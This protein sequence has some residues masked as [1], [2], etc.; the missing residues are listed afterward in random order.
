[1]KRKINL[2][3]LLSSMDTLLILHNSN[4]NSKDGPE[5][6]SY[7]ISV[8]TFLFFFNPPL[9]GCRKD[10]GKFTFYDISGPQTGDCKRFQVKSPFRNTIPLKSGIGNN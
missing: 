9:I 5:A 7:I 10:A 4:S 1:M 6:A 2:K 3:I 8:L